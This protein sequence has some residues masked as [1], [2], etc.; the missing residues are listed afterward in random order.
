MTNRFSPFAIGKKC[1]RLFEVGVFVVISALSGSAITK[2]ILTFKSKSKDKTLRSS[3][4]LVLKSTPKSA[5][6][7][8]TVHAFESAALTVAKDDT[9]YTSSPISCSPE[10][11][12]W[13]S[14]LLYPPIE[15]ETHFAYNLLQASAPLLI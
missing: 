4:E 15:P 12:Y 9:G 10:L 6:P 8:V 13:L 7:A 3:T 1:L 11:S 2:D 5:P 14:L